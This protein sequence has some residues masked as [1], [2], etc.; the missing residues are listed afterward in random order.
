MKERITRATPW[1]VEEEFACFLLRDH[2]LQALA[3]IYFE[4][5][6]NHLMAAELLT[7]RGRRIAVNSPNWA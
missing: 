5:K 6:L 1:S 3:Y 2:K 4:E 7:S